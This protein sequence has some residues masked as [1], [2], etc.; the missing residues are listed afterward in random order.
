MI[1]QFVYPAIFTPD[2]ED[3]GFVITFPDIP[4]A[5]TQ[6]DS[7]AMGLK[8][9]T[10]CLD[11]A[12]SGRLRLG[13][14]LP[15][16]STLETE[17]YLIYLPAQTATKALLTQ[18]LAESAMSSSELAKRIHCNK[19]AV[20]RLLDPKY[21]SPLSELETAFKAIGCQLTPHI[22]QSSNPLV[23]R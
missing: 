10:D 13:K 23:L 22:I 16:P 12:I 21:A 20:Q 4:E 15:P 6:A 1:T 19:K 3:G 14:P 7:I 5:I 17:H 9:A 11:E 2:T 8:E 18:A